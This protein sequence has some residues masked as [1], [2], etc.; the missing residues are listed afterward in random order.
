MAK[1]DA[2]A[3]RK[4]TAADNGSGAT[5]T[6]RGLKSRTVREILQEHPGLGTA[7]VQDLARGRG[8]AVTPADVANVRSKLKKKGL[9][10]GQPAEPTASELKKVMELGGRVGG[11]ATLKKTV[12]DLETLA[13]EVGGLERLKQCLDWWEGMNTK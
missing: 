13:S 8:V 6:K 2:S 10:R 7:E 5:A 9:L 1:K 3:S 12:R 11:L 4:E